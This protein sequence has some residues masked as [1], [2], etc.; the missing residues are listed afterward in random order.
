MKISTR[1]VKLDIDIFEE[2]TGNGKKAIVI[3]EKNYN[4]CASGQNVFE[5]LESFNRCFRTFRFLEMENGSGLLPAF[6][7]LDFVIDK[8]EVKF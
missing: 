7:N 2:E 4:L 6:C 3:V 8:V 5:A 1:E